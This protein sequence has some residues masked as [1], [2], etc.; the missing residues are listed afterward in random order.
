MA[1]TSNYHTHTSFCD[2]ANTPEEMVQAAIKA[3]LTELGF[4]G[5]S[6]LP[7]DPEWN[8]PPERAARYRAEIK[9]LQKAYADQI[10]ILLGIEQ[11]LC[12]PTDELAEYDFVIG[13]VHCLFVDGHY[14]SV[15]LSEASLQQDIDR[16]YG[17]NVYAFAEHYYEE[18]ATL[19]EKT[20]CNM[21]AHFDLCLKFMEQGI[22]IDPANPRY[23]AA[24]DK[25]LD[26]LLKTPVWF[27]INTG[28]VA[29]GYRSEFYPEERILKRLGEAGA[30]VVLSSDSH[31]AETINYGFS[32]AEELCRRLHLNLQTRL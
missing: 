22:S 28:A 17:G 32:E 19:Y 2:G 18:V 29:K 15:D 1:Y 5:H 24:A 30:K 26:A 23:I 25:A 31:A 10:H 14:V 11:D 20:H 8:M 27:E 7:F 21:I 16:Y 13:G 12:S 6:Y 9:R 4:S 3:G